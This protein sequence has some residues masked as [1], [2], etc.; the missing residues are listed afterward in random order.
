MAVH[1]QS[2]KNNSKKFERVLTLWFSIIQ[3]LQTDRQTDRQEYY[4]VKKRFERLAAI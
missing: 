2:K 1:R 3:F 4:K